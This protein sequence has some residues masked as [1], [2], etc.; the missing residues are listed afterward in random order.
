MFGYPCPFCTQRLL[1]AP[2]RAGQRTICPKCLKPIVIPK[3]DEGKKPEPVAVAAVAAEP[4]E[5][6]ISMMPTGLDDD[7]EYISPEPSD[8]TPMPEP[9][10]P[11][12]IGAAAGTAADP[13]PLQPAAAV[14]VRDPESVADMAAP[15]ETKDEDPP[16]TPGPVPIPAPTP[17]VPPSFPDTYFPPVA[18]PAPGPLPEPTSFPAP[19]YPAPGR[20]TGDHPAAALPPPGGHAA[21]NGLIV[22]NPTDVEAADIAAELTQAIARTMKPAPEPPSDLRLT[23]G[24]WI[25]L[26][27]CGFALWLFCMVSDMEPLKNVAAVGAVEL[28]IGYLWV[29]VAF[30]QRS[31]KQ[32]FV[33]LF[34]PVWVYRAANPPYEPGYRPLRFVVAGAVLLSLYVI[35]PR[36]QPYLNAWVGI[37]PDAAPAPPE[38][39]ESPLLKLLAAERDRNTLAIKQHLAFFAKTESLIALPA[40]AKPNVIELL[41]RLARHERGEVR[42]DALRALVTWAQDDAKPAVLRAVPSDDGDERTAAYDLVTR[43]ADAETVKVLLGR[44]GSP[45]A[46]QANQALNAIGKSDRGRAAIEDALLPLLKDRTNE[47]WHTYLALAGEF[48]GAKAAAAVEE[49][50]RASGRASEREA[51]SQCLATIRA[52]LRR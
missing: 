46:A 11:A 1:A 18:Y 30:G 9:R 13:I 33:T 5:V 27:A 19:D 47:S 52:R 21:T 4:D 7:D 8:P 20:I 37:T 31:V 15:A 25:I 39:V 3:P 44:I 14:L 23:T 29:A 48:G 36:V 17:Y 22:F 2:E 41:Q 10:P 28:V 38:A 12:R 6:P 51:L 26:T 35:G 42:E 45:H 24:L 43:W 40:A 32:G 50:R 49:L 34:P 16:L